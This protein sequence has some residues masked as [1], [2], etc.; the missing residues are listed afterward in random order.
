MCKEVSGDRF[1]V[2]RAPFRVRGQEI[3]RKARKE[4]L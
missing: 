4:D 1:K 3:S 2:G